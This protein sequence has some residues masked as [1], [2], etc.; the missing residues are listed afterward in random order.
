MK[1]KNGEQRLDRNLKNIP[2]FKNQNKPSFQKNRE[3]SLP[4]KSV[5]QS[6][7]NMQTIFI[8]DKGFWGKDSCQTKRWHWDNHTILSAAVLDKFLKI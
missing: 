7:S 3:S 1:G 8:P 6:K 4:I 2:S 5:D